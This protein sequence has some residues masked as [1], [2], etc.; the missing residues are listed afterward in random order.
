M[1]FKIKRHIHTSVISWCVPSNTNTFGPGALGPRVLL[2]LDFGGA[3]A[4]P[5]NARK[6]TLPAFLAEWLST[7]LPACGP[8]STTWVIEAILDECCQASMARA[9]LWH[10]FDIIDKVYFYAGLQPSGGTPLLHHLCT[11][12]GIPIGARQHRLFSFF[13]PSLSTPIFNTTSHRPPHTPNSFTFKRVQT[14]LT[15]SPSRVHTRMSHS[16]SRAQARFASQDFW[17]SFP[18]GLAPYPIPG[19][20]LTPS[21]VF[22]LISHI[23]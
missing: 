17:P 9:E 10:A 15:Q 13:T 20:Y 14:P 19:S 21:R 5:H 18:Q 8:C 11:L 1:S 12:G 7:P 2:E 4:W 3:L 23:F 6:T 22:G 16:L